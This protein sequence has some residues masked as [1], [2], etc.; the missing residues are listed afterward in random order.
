MR[1]GRPGNIAIFLLLLAGA[2]AQG[3]KRATYVII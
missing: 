1:A 3:L 2:R